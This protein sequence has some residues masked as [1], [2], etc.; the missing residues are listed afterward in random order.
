[1][2]NTLIALTAAHVL[3]DFVLQSAGMVQYKR[4]VGVFLLHILVVALSALLAL[5]PRTVGDVLALVAFVA[6]AHGLIDAIKTGLM[7]QRPAD[8]FWALKLFG[9]DQVAHIASLVAGAALWPA[10]FEQGFWPAVLGAQGA[11]MLVGAMVLG[12]G[13]VLATRVGAIVIGLLMQGLIEPETPTTQP[14]TASALRAGIWIG[15]LERGLVFGFVLLDQFAAIGFVIAAKSILRFEYARKAE[16]SERVI[17][18]TM[19]SF[20]WAIGCAVLAQRLWNVV[21]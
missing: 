5:G 10:V 13:L 9:G 16:Q 19:A 4:R 11:S 18:G 12:T 15:W 17:I 2:L 6:A 14:P 21:L 3:A 20:G 7:P 1:M 8:A